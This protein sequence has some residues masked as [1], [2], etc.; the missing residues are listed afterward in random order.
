[1]PGANS[2]MFETQ[3]LI[4]FKVQGVMGSCLPIIQKM[5]ST[6]HNHI[7]LIHKI[8]RLWKAIIELMSNKAN[9][10]FNFDLTNKS[11]IINND[12]IPVQEKL[13]TITKRDKRVECEQI[14]SIVKPPIL[15]GL[16]DFL[17]LQKRQ[18]TVDANRSQA[19]IL[20]QGNMPPSVF[21]STQIILGE[22]LR[23]IITRQRTSVLEQA[24]PRQTRL[25]IG[26]KIFSTPSQPARFREK[27][28]V[29]VKSIIERV[30]QGNIVIKPVMIG[31]SNNLKR[32]SGMF[33]ATNVA[34]NHEE[35]GYFAVS[36]KNSPEMSCLL[37]DSKVFPHSKTQSLL[38][39]MENDR[40]RRPVKY[41][42]QLT[43][44]VNRVADAG[45]IKKTD[46]L[47]YTDFERKS[48]TLM[49]RRRRLSF[50]GG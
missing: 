7:D 11:L 23:Q 22:F 35:L 29:I 6:T 31:I 1:M 8:F 46:E 49:D 45:V 40:V 3:S 18:V 26:K 15:K 2:K 25:D 27:D 34:K 10:C 20:S 44:E 4:G 28:W 32:M 36:E 47:S 37:R 38:H 13:V 5:I 17:A 41:R 24:I 39:E 19:K 43:T 12:A 21:M 42:S 14:I 33:S 16:S 50:T 9:S 30:Y 48:N